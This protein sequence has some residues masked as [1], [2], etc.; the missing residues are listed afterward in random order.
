MDRAEI[1]SVDNTIRTP[2]G[3]FSKSLKTREGTA[4][5]MWEIEYKVYALGIGLVH[6]AEM[7][8]TKYGMVTAQK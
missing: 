3:T 1:V 4:M 8:L 5:N 7:H 6:D 2:A